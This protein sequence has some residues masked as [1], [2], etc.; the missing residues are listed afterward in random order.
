MSEERVRS[1]TGTTWD[2]VREAVVEEDSLEE[3]D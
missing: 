1:D 2:E 3:A